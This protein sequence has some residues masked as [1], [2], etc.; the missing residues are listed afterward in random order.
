MPASDY[1]ARALAL[2]LEDDTTGETPIWSRRSA[3]FARSSHSNRP[4]TFLQ[5]SIATAQTVQ[6]RAMTQYNKLSPVQKVLFS[7]GG[8]VMFVISILFLVY[9][10]RIFG[11]LLPYA[12]RWRDVTAGWLVLWALIFTVSF[13]PL[14]GYS[15][16]LT[17]AGFVYGFPNGWFI[18]ASATVAGSTA[19]FL[20]SR[21]LLRTMVTRLIANDKR[22]AALALTLKHDG[23]KLLVMIRMCPLPYSLSNGAVATFPTVHAASFALATA[24]VSPKLMLHIFIGSQLEKIAESGG[25]MDARTKAISYLSI[26]IGAVAG[27]A[28]GWFMYKKTKERAAELEE[29]ERQGVRRTSVEE[30]ENEYADDPE[31]LSAAEHLREEED[32]ISLRGGWDDEYTDDV[33]DAADIG[34]DPFKDGDATDEEERRG[35]K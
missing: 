14:I 15:S 30:L 10:E 31:A 29:E 27:V 9:N 20:L 13:P 11:A 17:I 12:K 33:D 7:V 34:D 21:T 32:D 1:D 3:S 19:S 18:A 35:R 6:R 16:L 28:T 24:I 2:P 23:L 25:K 8:V 5:R 22:F 4:Q 26:A